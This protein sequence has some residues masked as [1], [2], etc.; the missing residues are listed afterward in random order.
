MLLTIFLIWVLSPAVIKSYRRGGRRRADAR[1]SGPRARVALAYA[2]WR[3]LATDF[4]ARYPSDTPLQFL[5]R[6][7]P[8]PEH[9]ELA[10]LTT[11]A[12]WGDL[13]NECTSE[14]ASVAEE[15][16]RALRKRMSLAQP[17]T[18]RAVAAVSRLSLNDPF[19]P[20]PPTR[21]Q[22]KKL[23]RREEKESRQ[24][25]LLGV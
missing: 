5:K 11:R 22:L 15:L 21:R 13:R 12:L 20:I 1:G 7:P 16:S 6:F 9:R 8:D 14:L 3:D 10:W 18:L 23:A 4:G 17:G 24:N 19:V 2:E 25:E